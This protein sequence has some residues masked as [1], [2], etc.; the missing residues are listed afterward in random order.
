MFGQRLY[1]RSLQRAVAVAGLA[2][3]SVLV[4][5]A[6]PAAAAAPTNDTIAGA[7]VITSLP[8]LDSVDTTEAT[9]DADELAAAQPCL[10]LGAPAIE[11]AVWYT[12]TVQADTALAVDVTA[13][14]YSAGIAAFAGPPSPDTFL[15]CSPGTLSGPVSAG[16]T[17]HLMVFA[18]VPD[19]PGRTLEISISETVL[20]HVALTV[21]PI[22][23]FD[24]AGS[25]TVS[26]TASCGGGALTAGVFG[27]V[28]QTVGRFAVTGS[29]FVEVTCD[30][31]IHAWTAHVLPEGGLFAGGRAS[32]DATAFACS[33]AGCADV[34]VQQSIRLRR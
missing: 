22:G 3:T 26:G 34:S 15:T 6:A 4:V 28:R 27:R 17:V 5:A 20:P 11:R 32:V 8:F 9:T 23:R 16:Q 19:E 13:S 1:T 24:A 31:T 10:A 7:T 12:G 2:A 25:V 33:Q 29:F 30:D 14:N 18:F 21:D